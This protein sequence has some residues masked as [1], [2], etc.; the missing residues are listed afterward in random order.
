MSGSPAGAPAPTILVVDDEPLIREAVTD[1]LRDCGF[2]VLEACDA[3][4]AIEILEAGVD[5]DV[6]FS[7]IRMPSIGG[8][9]LAKWVSENRPGTPMFLA[10]G[11]AGK[12]YMSH[13]LCGAQFF[14][15]PY[16]LKTVS[17]K[18]HEAVHARRQ[19]QQGRGPDS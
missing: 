8:V 2:L 15:K 16:P 4:E 3:E 18:F 13:E 5:V 9:A 1:H 7:D 6:V 17:D 12:I 10:S 14:Q 19:S 11:D